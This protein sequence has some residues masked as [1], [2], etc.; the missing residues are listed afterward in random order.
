MRERRKIIRIAHVALGSVLAIVLPA[1]SCAEWCIRVPLNIPISL[2]TGHVRTPEFKT[3]GSYPYAIEITA[4]TVL[5]PTELS[6]KLGISEGPQYPVD[7][8]KEPLIEADWTVWSGGNVVAHGSSRDLG[9]EGYCRGNTFGRLIGGFKANK[10]K[11]YVIDLNFTRDGSALA[12]ADPHLVVDSS[13]WYIN[14]IKK[15][16]N[17]DTET[18]F[19]KY[20]SLRPGHFRSSEFEGHE[21]LNLINFD[22]LGRLPANRLFCLIGTQPTGQPACEEESVLDFDW[23]VWSEGKIVATGTSQPFSQSREYSMYSMDVRDCGGVSRIFRDIGS[24]QGHK[25][26]KFSL[27]L[28]IKKDGSKLDIALPRLWVQK[29]YPTSGFGM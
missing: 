26:Q 19:S 28:N 16:P 10:H 9:K 4:R 24:F 29:G 20:L 21:G 2:A 7:C 5:P 17:L 22:V 27:E 12:I 1:P 14:S 18:L 6:C 8:N 11:T 25:G 13:E 15:N 3:T 23:T